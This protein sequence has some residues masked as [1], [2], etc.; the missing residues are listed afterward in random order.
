MVTNYTGITDN[1]LAPVAARLLK[2]R[3]GQVLIICP[4]L[5]R[6]RRIASDLAFFTDQKVFVLPETDP[7]AF[8]F[9]AKSRTDLTDMLSALTALAGGE[10][11]VVVAPVLAALRKLAP[12]DVFLRDVITVKTGERLFR[13]DLAA[14]LVR[15]GYERSHAAE[16]FGQFAVRGDIVDIFAPGSDHPVRVEFFDD[17]VDSIRSYDALTQRSVENLEEFTVFPAELIVRGEEDNRRGLKAISAAYRGLPARR[18]YLIE[19]VEEGVN[20][21]YL[22][23]FA[24]YF[25][26]QPG[27]I[28]D[29]LTDP[30]FVMADDPS[31]IAEVLDFYEKEQAEIQKQLI[32]RQEAVASDLESHPNPEDL[33]KINGIK[34]AL[35]TFWCTPFSQQIRF[36]KEL[37][38]LRHIEARQA[39]VYAGHMDVLETDLKRFVKEGYKV[40]IACSTPDRLVNLRDFLER[41]GLD[42][43]VE[44][45]DGSLAAGTEFPLERQL[46]LSEADIF[47][48]SKKAR[49]HRAKGAEIK[50]FTD[51]KK[52]DYVVHEAH[53]VGRFTGVEKLTVD[54]STMD[55]LKIQYAGADVLYVPVDQ[56][57]NLQK[58]VGSEGIEPKINKLSGT[59]WQQTKARAKAAIR[60][61]T[62]EY[63]KLSAKRQIAKGYEFGPDTTWQREFEDAF[64]YQ[65]TEDQ[66][67]CAEEIKKDMQR[68]V[69]MDRLLC[70]DVG[71]GKTEVAARAIFKCLEEGKQ[72]A[73]LVPTTILANQHYNT[74]K[75]RFAAYPF[76]VEMLSRFRTDKQQ[77]EIAERIAT[78]E[79]D[80]VVGTHRIL[81]QDVKFKDLGLLVIDEE[82]RFGVEHKEAIK[83]LKENVDVL[84]LSATP[85]PRTLHMSLIG[86]RDM[87]VIEE[88]PEDRYPVQTYVM[89]Q[90][91]IL[92]ADAI[93]RELGRGGQVY[94]VYNRVRGINRVAEHLR[95][96]VPEAK[97]T[98]AHGQMGEKQLEDVM[99]DFTSGGFDVLVATTIIESGLDI[100]NVNTLIVLDADR[101]GLAQL[102][103]LRGRVGRSSR[104]AYAYLFYKKD[105]VLTEVAEKRLRA[106]R[107]FTEFGSGFR[108]AMRDLELRGAGN[109][110]GVE[111]SGHMLSI[112]YELYCKLVEEA[113]DEL[114]GE[115]TEAPVRADTQVELGVSAFI[116]ERY[117]ADERTRLAMYKRIST[118][119]SDE[120]R[121]ETEGELLDRFGDLPQE[122]Q[123]LLDV[124][125]VRN[126]ASSL[127]IAKLVKQQGK[128]L[129]SFEQKNA[130]SPEVF[131][132]LMDE[133]GNSI[134]IYGG[135]EPRISVSISKGQSAAAAALKFLK[136]AKKGG[137]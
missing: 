28:F 128:I 66:L 124:A 122:A 43:R 102:Y 19:C 81:S 78:G 42:G 64:P 25:Y 111:Q 137:I 51:I 110:L 73:V 95:E 109:I 41:A 9:E 113:A 136:T 44:L 76:C 26:E 80:L 34:S 129:A 92:I 123:N 135:V 13:E 98:A 10:K 32:E 84:T 49:K 12:R 18:D 20:T 1:Q 100:P 117:I 87:S 101:F 57:D 85:I 115:V 36:A 67:R 62:E 83:K 29:Y 103:Q 126:L 11:A 59:E 24:G 56:L 30:S 40:V 35:G 46:F 61:M 127:G 112:G 77:K 121:L 114:S 16:G 27:L 37:D 107:E 105:K 96:L 134:T 69:P 3:P 93:K 39:P 31:R 68:P 116:P 17:E 6:A 15:M 21:Q 58:Y 133:L 45:R 7:V 82:Q 94:V 79:V 119:S 4:S 55:Y 130:L 90:D 2:T 104:M 22:E 65:E 5:T 38:A 108:V 8:R 86:I 71:Y 88:P 99:M 60:D 118:I 132:A 48:S 52:G 120:D 33:A 53:G 47:V 50:V 125:Y 74:F 70:G 106:I 89:E 54:G 72:A 14:R 131:A 97:I 91:D 23:G 75:E 63:L